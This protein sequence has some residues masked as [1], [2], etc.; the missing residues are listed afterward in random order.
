MDF[1]KTITDAALE[2]CWV[3]W[4]ALSS[5]PLLVQLLCGTFLVLRTIFFMLKAVTPVAL[6]F[7]WLLWRVMY[8]APRLVV[9]LRV[10]A[11]RY[12]RRLLV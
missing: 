6:G 8:F 4:G 3:M 9:R 7:C 2:L 11:F 5:S 10:L 1:F 12:H